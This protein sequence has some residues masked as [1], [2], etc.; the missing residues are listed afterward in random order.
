MTPGEL[1]VIV[2][3]LEAQG[4]P[5][6]AQ[7]DPWGQAL[8]RNPGAEAHRK[9]VPPAG[10]TGG[11]GTRLSSPAPRDDH[12][13][14]VSSSAAGFHLDSAGGHAPA[15]WPANTR[16]RPAILIRSPD[17]GRGRV[18]GRQRRQA[19]AARI[20]RKQPSFDAA[21]CYAPRA[22]S[23]G[24]VGAELSFGAADEYPS[25]RWEGERQPVAAAT[26]AATNLRPIDCV[27]G[28]AGY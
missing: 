28:G 16:R 26:K 22:A 9:L 24:H 11:E 21:V 8:P 27:W 17:G 25:H 12:A 14:V 2:E 13:A 7:I 3:Q 23:M 5:V 15:P 4:R 18:A 20:T 6:A 1:A 19:H 10:L